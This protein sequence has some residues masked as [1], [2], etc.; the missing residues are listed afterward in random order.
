MWFFTAK[1]DYHMHVNYIIDIL[2]LNIFFMFLLPTI[3][4]HKYMLT[5]HIYTNYAYVYTHILV[6]INLYMHN[7]TPYVQAH[8][9]FILTE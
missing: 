2:I 7:H 6:L 5:I 9:R 8:T 4:I 3:Y 1:V